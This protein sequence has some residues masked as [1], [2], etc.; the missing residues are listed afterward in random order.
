LSIAI[1]VG[2]AENLP[3]NLQNNFL[4]SPKVYGNDS[5]E[6]GHTQYAFPK[7][8]N[9]VLENLPSRISNPIM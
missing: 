9:A 5:L 1:P 3:P 4:K 6:S 7:K 8:G 2:S